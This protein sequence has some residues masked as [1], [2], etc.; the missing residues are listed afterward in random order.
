MFNPYAALGVAAVLVS[1]GVAADR[2]TP[3]IGANA[4]IAHWKSEAANWKDKAGKFEKLALS[5]QASF[6]QSEAYRKMEDERARKALNEASLQCSA[7]VERARLSASAIT[8]IITKEPA[9]DPN[10]CAIPKLVP[11]DELRDALGV[12][13]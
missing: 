11:S 7:R 12:E 13:D 6:R 2:F 4:R 10:G 1:A 3:I 5:W 8:A 9:R